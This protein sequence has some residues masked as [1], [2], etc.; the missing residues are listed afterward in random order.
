MQNA[1]LRNEVHKNKFILIETIKTAS[2]IN[3]ECAQKGKDKKV[4][5]LFFGSKHKDKV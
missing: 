1:I 3:N 2:Y 4:N 5:A